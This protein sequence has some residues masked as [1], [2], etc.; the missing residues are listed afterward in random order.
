MHA[1]IIQFLSIPVT[2][3]SNYSYHCT[4]NILTIWPSQEI[5][6]KCSTLYEIFTVQRCHDVQTETKCIS[7]AFPHKSNK[8][9]VAECYY[10]TDSDFLLCATQ[11]L[12]FSQ[13]LP[14]YITDTVLV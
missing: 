6:K 1:E 5:Q 8:G 13:T 14:D 7:T 9:L 3:S 12:H 2:S 11:H 10:R 4:E